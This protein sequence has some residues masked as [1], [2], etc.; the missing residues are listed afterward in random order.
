MSRVFVPRFRPPA[1]VTVGDDGIPDYVT[2]DRSDPRC[3]LPPPG[4]NFYVYHNGTRLQHIIEANRREG[5]AV[6]KHY[7]TR[8]DGTTV[9][10]PYDANGIAQH[11]VYQGDI[12]FRLVR[13][14]GRRA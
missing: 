14:K 3:Y 6:G 9:L 10:N 11:R 4:F 12:T 2:A 5:W 7:F 8:D 13:K 1:G